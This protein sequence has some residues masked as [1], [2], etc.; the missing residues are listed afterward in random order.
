MKH[1]IHFVTY[2]FGG[3]LSGVLIK[4]CVFAATNNIV[5]A[6]IAFFI[7]NIWCNIAIAHD[8]YRQKKEIK[9]G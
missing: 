8:I 7:W 5:L 6:L 2:F 9:N 4:K 3:V 1:K